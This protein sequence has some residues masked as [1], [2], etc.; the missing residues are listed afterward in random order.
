M[1]VTD[2]ITAG[3]EVAGTVGGGKGNKWTEMFRI[4]MEFLARTRAR[5]RGAANQGA[6]AYV[7]GEQAADRVSGRLANVYGTEDATRIAWDE[8]RREEASDTVQ[9]RNVTADQVN[10]MLA[11]VGASVGPE[12]QQELAAAAGGGIGSEKALDV[13][14]GEEAATASKPLS[15]L[16]MA[17]R[18]GTFPPW[19]STREPL[20]I[21]KYPWLSG[22]VDPEMQPRALDPDRMVTGGGIAGSSGASTTT[23]AGRGRGGMFTPT[24]LPGRDKGAMPVPVRG[25]AAPPRA[26]PIGIDFKGQS[27]NI[28]GSGN[29]YDLESIRGIKGFMSDREQAYELPS[30]LLSAMGTVESGLRSGLTSPKGAQGIMQVMP[31]ALEA[32]GFSKEEAN[33]IDRQQPAF[34]IDKGAAYVRYLKNKYDSWVDVLAAYNGGEGALNELKKQGKDWR[35]MP[36]ETVRYVEKVLSLV[37]PGSIPFEPGSSRYIQGYSEGGPVGGDP[38][39][40]EGVGGGMAG[41]D[42]MGD[43]D[44]NRGAEGE[45]AAQADA[46]A[47]END[48]QGA[49]GAGG[50]GEPATDEGLVASLVDDTE[51]QTAFDAFMDNPVTKA[52]A[53][54]IPAVGQV[55]GAVKAGQ[56][57]TEGLGKFGEAIGMTGTATAPGIPSVGSPEAANTIAAAY[58]RPYLY[59]NMAIPM[60]AMAEGGQP[61][62]PPADP[63]QKYVTGGGFGG[64]APQLALPMGG[65][66]AG[67]GPATSPAGMVYI[68]NPGRQKQLRDRQV[69]AYIRMARQEG[70]MKGGPQALAIGMAGIYAGKAKDQS[71]FL[72]GLMNAQAALAAGDKKSAMQQL[73]S[74]FSTHPSGD[75]FQIMDGGGPDKLVAMRLDKD[76]NPVKQQAPDGRE[77]PSFLALTP[78]SLEKMVDLYRNPGYWGMEMEKH[79]EAKSIQD[80]RVMDAR[81]DMIGNY[82]YSQRTAATNATT[83]KDQLDYLKPAWDK[84]YSDLFPKTAD[85]VDAFERDP[86]RLAARNEWDQLS[87]KM[88]E[89]E[90]QVKAQGGQFNALE[91]Q[92]TLFQQAIIALGGTPT[93]AQI[94]KW[95]SREW[96][97]TIDQVRKSP[98]QNQ[99][100]TNGTAVA[101]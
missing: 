96:A 13:R 12:T 59:N 50:G 78:Q 66:G 49:P 79:I 69:A 51:S 10:A 41:A 5:Q 23:G 4:G 101:P 63:T 73:A 82:L 31:I 28:P 34:S 29:Q 19:R 80:K 97:D 17:P 9:G 1:N 42:G 18:S 70:K 14:A 36:R 81:N 3:A 7:A 53:T 75:R 68:S 45:A 61:V 55:Y 8:V 85:E 76:G 62:L 88:D 11:N 58:N 92:A 48:A 33:T 83:P 44:A 25:P 32:L 52:V 93:S 6:N 27:T 100:S 20:D 64:P 87:L 56:A 90:R 21:E 86:A 35:S 30:G 22:I 65:G 15:G 94:V 74:G 57:I 71:I 54:A 98:Q 72:R 39:G 37:P 26:L 95:A 60:Q 38:H 77:G 47:A 89:M 91:A 84:F 40:G 43:H 67:A 24:S 16:E 99:E 2:I 46:Q